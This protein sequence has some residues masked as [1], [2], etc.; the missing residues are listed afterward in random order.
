MSNSSEA[1]ADQVF[2]RFLKLKRCLRQQARQ[3]DSRGISPRNFA[4]L[5]F[6]LES[7][8]ATVG[9]VQAYLYQSA[10]TASTVIAQLE[11][12]GYVTRTRSEQDNRVVVVELTPA[13]QD[14]AQNTPLTGF[15]LLRRRLRALPEK[16]LLLIDGVLAEIMQL[17]EVTGSE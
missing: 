12:A 15:P 10:S 6:L 16:R 13:G 7:G 5:R 3:M 2:H 4:V 11:E 8:S 14:I 17:L 9:E 1:L